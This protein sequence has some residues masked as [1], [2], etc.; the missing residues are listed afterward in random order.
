VNFSGFADV[1]PLY[2]ENW[3][4]GKLQYKNASLPILPAL[5]II[6]LFIRNFPVAGFRISNPY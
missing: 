3:L 4:N 5:N 2:D 6:M 1:S